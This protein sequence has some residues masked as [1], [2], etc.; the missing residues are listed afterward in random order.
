MENVNLTNTVN[1]IDGTNAV[2]DVWQMECHADNM[3]DGKA[4]CADNTTKNLLGE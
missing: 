4:M 1:T 3:A 2:C